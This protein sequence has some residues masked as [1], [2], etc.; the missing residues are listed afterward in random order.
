VRTWLPLLL[1]ALTACAPTV[2]VVEDKR[3]TFADVDVCT[4]LKDADVERQQLVGTK[5][6]GHRACEFAFGG[7]DG[8]VSVEVALLAKPY[9]EANRFCVE[10]CVPGASFTKV[11]G[12]SMVRKCEETAGS[13]RCEGYAEVSE[14]KTVGLVVKR[15]AD[16]AD[17]LGRLTDD[18]AQKL[19][20]HPA[21]TSRATLPK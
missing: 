18:I 3:P 10:G 14:Q 8:A 7:G 21:V 5:P 12:G 4:V 13:M 9:R 1:L 6:A 11:N 20:N 15:T 16:S 2:H 17:A 19:L